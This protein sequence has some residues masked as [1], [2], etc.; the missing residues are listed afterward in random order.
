MAGARYWLT[1]YGGELRLT[2]MDQLPPREGVS[3]GCFDRRSCPQTVWSDDG[4]TVRDVKS[5]WDFQRLLGSTTPRPDDPV[6]HEYARWAAPVAPLLALACV[7]PMSA[8]A[9][10]A[11]RGLRRRNRRAR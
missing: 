3:Y 1:T 4:V 2:R 9:T 5:G 7:L 11:H 8:L 10:A 6:S